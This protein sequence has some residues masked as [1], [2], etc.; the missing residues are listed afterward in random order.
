MS[1]PKALIGARV[2]VVGY[3]VGKIE[4]FRKLWSGGSPHT[5]LFDDGR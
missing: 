5:V 1:D 3:G 4:S 2:D